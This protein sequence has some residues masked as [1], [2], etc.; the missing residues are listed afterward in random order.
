MPLIVMCGIPCS[1]KTTVT[2]KIA[3]YMEKETGK[4]VEI[5][6]EESL[7]LV[8]QAAYRGL[9]AFKMEKPTNFVDTTVEKNTRALLRVPLPVGSSS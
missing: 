7:N 8:K 4:R 2:K 1:G 9:R 6:N 5:I 3:A